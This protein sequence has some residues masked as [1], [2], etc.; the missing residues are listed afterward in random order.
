MS[1]KVLEGI[2]SPSALL[3]F[4]W[5][6][7]RARARAREIERGRERDRKR[8]GEGQSEGCEGSR[9]ET[10]RREGQGGGESARERVFKP[11]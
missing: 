10:G 9:R 11:P 8:G 1:P 2:R 5:Q 7:E 3:S 6:R 4:T